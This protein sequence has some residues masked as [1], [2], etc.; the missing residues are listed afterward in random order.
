MYD[1]FILNEH[2]EN[3][4]AFAAWRHLLICDLNP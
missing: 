3:E 1:D 2:V 4:F